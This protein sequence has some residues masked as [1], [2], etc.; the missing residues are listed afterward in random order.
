MPNN[1]IQGNRWK[2]FDDWDERPL[3]QDQFA[4][5]DPKEGFAAWKGTK[6]P[7]PKLRIFLI[8]T[9]ILLS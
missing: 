1:K 8:L 4:V 3:S 9:Y 5:E 7:K 6:D 2:R